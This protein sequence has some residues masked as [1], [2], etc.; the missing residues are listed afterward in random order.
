MAGLFDFSQ[1]D[2]PEAAGQLAF[3]AGLLN[4]GGPSRMPVSVGQALAQ[5]LMMGRNTATL[6]GESQRRNALTDLQMI[7]ARAHLEQMLKEQQDKAQAIELM[8]QFTQTPQTQAA[9]LPGGPTVANAAM[10][11]QM[12]GGFNPDAMR[13]ASMRAGNL[14]GVELASKLAKPPISPITA[15]PGEVLLDPRTFKTLASVPDRTAQT[16]IAKLVQEMN[17]LPPDSPLVEIYRQAIAKATTHAPAPTAISYGSPV[18]IQLQG[19]GTGYAQPPNRAGAAP[20]ILTGP[21]GKPLVRPSAEDTRPMTDTQANANLYSTRMERA[22]QIINNLEG[23][24]NRIWL[25]A[26][27]SAG[28]GVTGSIANARLS[29][30]AQQ[31]DQAQ[32]DFL[33]A[34]LRRESGAVIS[35]SEFANGRQQYFPQPGDS[36]E[37]VRQKAA[38]RRTAIEGVRAAA[39]PKAP[40]IQSTPSATNA[41][42]FRTAEEATAY[43]LRGSR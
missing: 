27:Q 20:Q 22:D 31:I 37:V 17:A 28:E 12:P 32:R 3:S 21:D 13:E 33:N 8:R 14:T 11:P 10:I 35:P 9:S 36:V 5:A 23:K 39:G 24:Y 2:N 25:A 42:V 1:Y 7:Q 26:R 41:P 15:K 30:E 40:N 38:N 18:P 43:Y 4:A 29:P 19:G 6:A 16:E 34:V